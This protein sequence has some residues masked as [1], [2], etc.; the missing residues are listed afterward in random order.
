M[1]K[2][3]GIVSDK[4]QLNES[5]NECGAMPAP[6]N[7]STT[8]PVSMNV[9][10]NAQGVEQIKELLGLMNSA[11][12]AR[13]SEPMAMPAPGMP[14]GAPAPAP[15]VNEPS[16]TDLIKLTSEPK[17]EEGGDE[18]GSEEPAPK[19]EM[20]QVA[21]EVR[22]MADT[23]ANAPDEKYSDIDAA[24][25]NGDDLNREKTQYKRAQPGDN[26]MATETIKGDLI[27]LYNQ[28]KESKE[29]KA[30]KDYDG[31]GEVESEKDEVWGSRM[32]AAKKATKEGFDADAKVGDKFKTAKGTATKTATGVRH[33]R[34]KYDYDPGSDD[35]A[36]KKMKR[37]AKKKATKEGFDADAKVGDTFKTAKGTA[38]KTASGVKHTRDKYE[39]DPGSDDKSDKK[40]KRDAKKK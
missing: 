9:T 33:T 40:M 37:D 2:L 7:Q 35:V 10:M 39:Y 34:D 8:P 11:D 24:V 18:E 21:D 6:M 22:D 4:A 25:P 31:D 20:K 19:G 36:D 23:L 13:M 5:V 1:K 17:P 3:L 26:P 28:I 16:M 15:A 14:I 27:K 12:A 30:K 38:T 32:K 29:K